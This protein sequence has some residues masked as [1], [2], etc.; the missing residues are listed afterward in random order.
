MRA[1]L[2]GD[3]RRSKERGAVDIV[4][5]A[6][7]GMALSAGGGAVESAMERCASRISPVLSAL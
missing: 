3:L 1:A 2:P 5:G 6:S 7:R 4:W